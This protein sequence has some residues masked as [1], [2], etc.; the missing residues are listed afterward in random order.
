MI[1]AWKAE[2]DA[3]ARD[4]LAMALGTALSHT[5][6]HGVVHDV[7]KADHCTDAIRCDVARRTPHPERRRVALAAIRDENVLIELAL[8]AEHDDLR[9]GAA[10]HVRTPWGRRKLADGTAPGMAALRGLDPDARRAS[11]YVPK[12]LQRH[13]VQ[14]PASRHWTG[15]GTAAFVDI[16]GFTKLSERLARKGKEG[17]EQITDAIGSSFDS[18]LSVARENGGTLLKFGGDALL[19]W[20][21]GDAHAARACHATFL[22]RRVLRDVGRIVVP[23]AKVTLRMSQGVHS[24]AFHFF[25]VGNSHLE[26]LPTGPAW[27]RLVSMEHNAT[28][29]QILISPETGALLPG[30]CLGDAKGPGVLLKREPSGWRGKIGGEPQPVLAAATLARGLSPAIRAHV[31]SGTVTPEHRPVTIAFIRYE[32]TDALIEQDGPAAAADALQRLVSAVEIATEEQDVCFLGSD[33]DFDGGKLILT[34][35]APRVTG[36]DEE[37]MLLALRKIMETP[38][39][40][41]IR[42][43][44]NR[45]AVFAGEIGPAYRRTY[46]VMG[47]AVNL[48]ARLM[49]KAEPGLIYA[50]AE[51]LEHSNT[52]FRTTDL[53]PFA[54]KGKAQPIRAW[55]VGRAAGSRTRQVTLQSLRLIGRDTELAVLRGALALARAGAGRLVDIVGEPGLGKTRLLEALRED[56]ADMRRLHATCE[57]YTASTPYVLWRELLREL[58]G[59]SRDDADAM[60]VDRLRDAVTERVPE[61]LPWLPLIAGAFDIELG[62]TPEIGMLAEKNRRP[63]LHEVVSRF[64]EVMMPDAT[65]IEIEDAHHM[66]PASAELLAYVASSVQGR[67]WVIGVARRNAS[68]GFAGTDGDAVTRVELQPLAQKDALRMAQLGSEQHALAPHVLEVV[69][70]RSGGNPQFLRDLLR[71]AIQT[72]GVGGLPDSAEAAAMARIDALTPDDRALVRRAAVFGLTFH[73]RMLAW[74]ADEEGAPP[75]E[76]AAWMRLQELFEEDGEGYLRF[77]RSLLRDAAY[78]GL[79]FKLRRRMH[80]VVAAHLADEMDYPE[81]AAGILSLHH[82]EAG[83]YVAT[84]KYARIAGDRA[85]ALYAYLEAAGLYARALD[86]ARHIR[87][88]EQNDLAA[89]HEA[90]ADCWHRAAEFHKAADAYS[91]ANRLVAGDAMRGSRLY[92]KR[93]R[94]EERLGRNRQALAWAMRARKAVEGLEVPEAARHAAQCTAWYASMLYRQGRTHEALRWALRA[95]F[96]S[97][98]ANDPEALGGACFVMAATYAVLGREG[99]EALMKRSLDAYR[100]SGNLDRQASLLANLGVMCQWQGRWD[101]AMDY[102][103][104]GR[105]ESLKLGD[106]VNAALARINVAEILIDR[107]ELA[108]AEETLRETLPLWKA[109]RYRFFLG[110]CLSLLGRAAMRDGRLGEALQLLHEAKDN[111]MQVGADQELPAID[112]RIAE[113]RVFMQDADAAL[114]LATAMLGRAGPSN[115]VADVTAVLQR[116]RGFALLQRGEFDGARD[117]FD[118]GLAAARAKHDLFEVTVGLLALVELA[119]VAG[120]AP[121]PAVL[122]ESTSLLESL[123]IARPPALPPVA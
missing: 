17:A 60:V 29:N 116:V 27:S 72:G 35:G 63:K 8:A 76:P 44:I 5:A 1:A 20:F 51:V 62:P 26:L 74:L 86:A 115:G 66:D 107:G 42:A 94:L 113:C 84:W 108:E 49:A 102:Y 81:E 24:G 99:A 57:A 93:A 34:A 18:I 25:A 106:T 7:L 67:P 33:V 78:E 32:G 19:L 39:P 13:L 3:T 15:E 123:K 121:E 14:D 53:E 43:G 50:T 70:Q 61:L 65:L 95:E 114:E 89:I 87:E 101:E 75:P 110:A 10:A 119:R 69:A 6:D 11:L 103:E 59:I 83:E 120:E 90:Q 98:S 47:D 68:G 46:T 9:A 36:D 37:R 31:L 97:K 38:L 23:G 73:P 2:S 40:I 12:I 52:L 21:E 122:A 22:M 105:A 112:A 28:A 109:S 41:R 80:G 55:A 117:A 56:A 104:R 77:R 4:S 88:I 92:L 58:M 82:Y 118:K 85:Q 111:F 45:G 30:R 54:V 16:S 71:S 48:S 64:L 79:P 96:E 100:Q 91:A